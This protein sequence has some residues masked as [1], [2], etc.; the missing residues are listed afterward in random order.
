MPIALSIDPAR[1]Y[2]PAWEDAAKAGNVLGRFLR[3][4]FG[5]IFATG[6]FYRTL[7]T[8]R[9]NHAALRFAQ[10]HWVLSALLMAAALSIH[11][12]WYQD[13]VYGPYP[14]SP[15]VIFGVGILVIYGIIW[16]TTALAAR[17]TA[18]EAAYRGIRLPLPVV[19]RGMYYHSA[20]YLPVAIVA[21]AVIGGNWI[22]FRHGRITTSTA[23][24]YLIVLCGQVLV[25]AFYLFKMY[26][27]G[28]KG[29]MYANL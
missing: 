23:S 3:T 28:M 22:L 12:R 13:Y 19:L 25:S 4:T 27:T 1:R 14:L 11:V 8:R 20:H 10:V 18:W 29:M 5:V 26:W 7:A 9:D 24:T 2:P 15:R 16:G 17:L 6:R 21:L